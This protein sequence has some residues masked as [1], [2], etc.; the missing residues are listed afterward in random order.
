MSPAA[1]EKKSRKGTTAA[2]VA[3]APEVFG[4]AAAIAAPV[5][6]FASVAN[7][8]TLSGARRAQRPQRSRAAA[9]FVRRYAARLQCA[10]QTHV[11]LD[12]L[13]KRAAQPRID[14]QRL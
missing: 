7:N 10:P 11:C 6:G 9:H 3:D 13:W 4:A 2:T 12:S 5:T 1:P 8:R 14:G